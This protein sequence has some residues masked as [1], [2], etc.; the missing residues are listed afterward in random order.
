MTDDEYFKFGKTYFCLVIVAMILWTT[1]FTLMEH[2]N[3]L[4]NINREHRKEILELK[5]ELVELKKLI[6]V[7]K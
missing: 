1:V 7:M 6:E 2:F 5:Q 3:R 4:N